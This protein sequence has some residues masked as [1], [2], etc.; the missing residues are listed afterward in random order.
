MANEFFFELLDTRDDRKDAT[1]KR[2]LSRT[3]YAKNLVGADAVRANPE[4]QEVIDGGDGFGLVFDSDSIRPH[5][6]GRSSWVDGLY[7]NDKSFRFPSNLEREDAFFNEFSVTRVDEVREIPIGTFKRNAYEVKNRINEEI[8]VKHIWEAGSDQY[9]E[10]VAI[11]N[12]EVTLQTVTFAM[13]QQ[14]QE[15]NNTLHYIGFPGTE[16]NWYRF[17][18][19][20]IVPSGPASWVTTYSW[21]RDPGTRNLIGNNNGYSWPGKPNTIVDGFGFTDQGQGETYIAVPG[22]FENT[23]DGEGGGIYGGK[24]WSR[25]P[26]HRVVAVPDGREV[27]YPEFPG[28]VQLPPTFI[29]NI[30][31][32]II[33]DGNGWQNLPGDPF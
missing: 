28:K 17:T 18:Y 24:I 11:W 12:K 13:I 16:S 10:S 6:D 14:L 5:P 23:L 33:N 25:P 21:E 9:T 27:D 7:T 20:D 15:Q 8:F 1:G 32:P 31:Y 4:Y 26:F 29:L 3:W 30:K 2:Q 19:S 22:D